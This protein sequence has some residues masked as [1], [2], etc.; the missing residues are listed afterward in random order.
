[1]PSTPLVALP[2][3]LAVAARG[4]LP[5]ITDREDQMAATLLELSQQGNVATISDDSKLSRVQLLTPQQL[6][7]PLERQQWATQDLDF[8]RDREDWGG[9][10]DE[11]RDWFVWGMSAFFIGE[12]RCHH[13]VL[14]PRDGL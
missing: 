1:M 14:G 9:L 2:G 13:A 6:T 8:S 7:E 11:E 10:T 5:T 12:E 4:Q 3:G